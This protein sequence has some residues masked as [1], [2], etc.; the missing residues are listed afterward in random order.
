MRKQTTLIATVLVFA[1]TAFAAD[2]PKMETFLGYDFLRANS[3]TNIPAF[4][5]NGAGGQFAYN[6]NSWLG[7]A[8][9]LYAVHNGNVF[10]S[11]TVNGVTYPGGKLDNTSFF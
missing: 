10:G 7:A 8:A 2:P 4:S 5:A 9:D 6:F 3:A 1:G 11:A